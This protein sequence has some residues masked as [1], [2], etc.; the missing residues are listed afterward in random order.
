M[1]AIIPNNGMDIPDQAIERLAQ[2]LLPRIQAYFEQNGEHLP[3]HESKA[4]SSTAA[5]AQQPAA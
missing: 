4:A 3:D 5:D 2:F 1:E